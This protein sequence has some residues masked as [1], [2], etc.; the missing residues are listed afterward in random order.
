MKKRLI[1]AAVLSSMMV[2][3]ACSGKSD[4]GTI[5]ITN[6]SYDPTREFYE[7]Y[8]KI[9]E[10]YYEEKYGTKVD[11]IQSHGGSG[12]QAR[13]VVE[14]CNADVVTLALEHDVDLIQRTGLIDEGWIDEFPQDSSPYTSTIVFLVRKG[15]PKDINDWD[16]LIKDGV[17]VFGVTYWGWIDL[18]SSTTSEMTKRYGFVYVDADDYGKGTYNR[19]KKDSFYWYKHVIETNGSE[20]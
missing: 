7:K 15:N 18:V 9:F 3:T 10:S 16:D 12:S 4:D 14:G 1:I 19:Y 20:I 8:N 2:F 5:T 13:S 17:D 6:V 11:V